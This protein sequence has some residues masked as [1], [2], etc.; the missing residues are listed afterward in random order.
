MI[1]SDAV[2]GPSQSDT[3]A[4]VSKVRGS[5]SA[6]T[7]CWPAPEY[8]RID[9]IALGCRI[10]PYWIKA[11]ALRAAAAHRECSPCRLHSSFVRSL[12]R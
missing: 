6:E 4:L 7:G 8:R 3:T 12:P 2:T 10:R 1:A 11:A 9:G 5:T